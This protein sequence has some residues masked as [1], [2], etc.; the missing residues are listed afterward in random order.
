MADRRRD[1]VFLLVATL[2]LSTGLLVHGAGDNREPWGALTAVPI[3]ISPPIEYVPRD[4]TPV[5]Q[6]VWAFPDQDAAAVKAFLLSAGLDDGTVAA[7]GETARRDPAIAGLRLAPPTAI[8]RALAPDVR[9]RIYHQLA[10]SPLNFDQNAAY[11]YRGDS[12]D[13][14]L[15]T[16]R[17]AASTRALVDPLVYR[18]GPFLYL[19][20]IELVRAQLGDT[21]E[22]QTLIKRLLRHQST[23]VSLKIA[24]PDQIDSLTEYWGR[25]GRKTDIRPILESIADA[26]PAQ[27]ID[28]TNLLPELPRRLLHRYPKVRQVDLEKPQLANCFWTALN[29]F[30]ETP[31]DRFLDVDAAMRSLKEDYFIV[32][33]GFQLG[34]IVVFANR[35]NNVFHVASYVADNLVFTKNGSFSLAPWTL[36]PIDDLKG[37]YL[38]HVDDW[39]VRYYRRKDL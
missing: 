10:K 37:P 25:G 27:Q 13:E 26:G 16:T 8:I 36:I 2:V 12:I 14:W 23:L 5:A 7:L 18:D 22:F 1:T 24:N 33:D 29:F 3:V 38:G 31:D 9:S 20:D 28:I 17:L 32:H 21:L 39:V 19:A 11:Y 30:S 34:D 15:G 35:A 4:N 6:P